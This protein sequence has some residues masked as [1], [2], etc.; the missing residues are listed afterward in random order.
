MRVKTAADVAPGVAVMVL[1]DVRFGRIEDMKDATT[2]LIRLGSDVE[3]VDLGK[4]VVHIDPSD[5]LTAMW[6][7]SQAEAVEAAAAAAA[8][9]AEALRAPPPPAPAPPA[10]VPATPAP[11]APAPPEPEPIRAEIPDL[12]IVGANGRTR[13]A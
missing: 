8:R 7:N 9:A 10:P 6:L 2:A 13:P 1:V 5:A 12:I 11:P 4:A 3:E